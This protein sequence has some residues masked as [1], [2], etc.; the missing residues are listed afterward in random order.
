MVPSSGHARNG[1]KEMGSFSF[2]DA[3]R[4]IA[5]FLRALL[6]PDKRLN[7]VDDLGIPLRLGNPNRG[8]MIKHT[9]PDGRIYV[10]KGDGWYN[11]ETEKTIEEDRLQ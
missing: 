2:M 4:F 6:L 8:F 10:Y 7:A 11:Q 3:I 1:D 5:T 9:T